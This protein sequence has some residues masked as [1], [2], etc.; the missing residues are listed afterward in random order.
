VFREQIGHAHRRGARAGLWR[1]FLPSGIVE[2]GGDVNE[3]PLEV[4][5]ADFQGQDPQTLNRYTYTRNNPLKYVDPTGKYFVVEGSAALRQEAKQFISTLV[6]TPAGKAQVDAIAKDPRPTRIK[7]ASLAVTHNANGSTSYTNGETSLIAGSPGKLGGATIQL[8]N[9]NIASVA[10]ATN[11][12]DFQVGLTAMSHE[13]SNAVAALA[14]PTFQGAAAAAAAGDAPSQPG[15][16]NTTGGSAERE[17]SGIVALLGAA[18]T[19]YIPD[20]ASEETAEGIL[21]SGQMQFNIQ[22][23]PSASID[24]FELM[25]NQR[26]DA[27]DPHD[28]GAP[29]QA[30]PRPPE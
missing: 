28:S 25:P 30:Q 20:N 7:E 3:L 6:R 10:A 1:A 22:N 9:S 29:A 16:N 2:C 17:A 21:Q 12:S 14:A 19:Q 18:G 4:E 8:D 24:D 26:P 11:R 5:A 27:P 13:M 15:A 23:D